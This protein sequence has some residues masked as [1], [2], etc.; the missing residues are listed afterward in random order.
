MTDID[1]RTYN[2]W[3]NMK[4]RC[5]NPTHPDFCNYGARGIAVTADWLLFKNFV[6]D[7]GHC[8][9]TLQLERANNNLGYNK[10]NCVWATVSAQ[11]SNKRLYKNNKSG[12]KGVFWQSATQRWMAKSTRNKVVCWLYQ[13]PDFFEACCARKAWETLITN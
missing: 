4:Q 9:E 5:N 7:M 1:T 8:P 13:G 2:A 3:Y 11:Q 12:V 6:R 10:D